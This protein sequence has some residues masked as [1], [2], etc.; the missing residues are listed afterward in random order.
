M[1]TKSNSADTFLAIANAL[2]NN[3]PSENA[4]D[5]ANANLAIELAA[6]ITETYHD[7]VAGLQH[8][9]HILEEATRAFVVKAAA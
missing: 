6:Y 8:V 5:F 2:E 1:Q 3:N 9:A 4:K 7:P